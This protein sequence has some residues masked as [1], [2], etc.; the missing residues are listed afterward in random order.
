MRLVV[1][2]LA[3]AIAVAS[4]ALANESRVEVRGGAIWD[5]GVTEATAGVA[6][7]YD[8]DLGSKAFAGVEVSGDKILAAGYKV[9][10]GF[11]ARAGIK[12]VEGGKLFAAA[13]YTTENC[14][15]CEDSINAGVG[16]EHSLG[17]GLYAKA[18]Y[19]HFFVDQGFSD[20]DAV[21]VGLGMRF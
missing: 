1:L 19:R 14:N 7:G 4:P 20:S 15:L 9:A 3:A 5:G 17:G 10:F 6:A 16:Y 18:E 2:S 21:S 8:F 12:P 13:G 11:T